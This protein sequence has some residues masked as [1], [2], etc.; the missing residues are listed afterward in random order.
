MK[1][2]KSEACHY[3]S[4]MI[5][6]SANEWSQHRGKPSGKDELFLTLL[7]V[8]LDATMPEAGAKL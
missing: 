7:L 5:E 3:L 2:C 4:T 8:L 6:K 1:R